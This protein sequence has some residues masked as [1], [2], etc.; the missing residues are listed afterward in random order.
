M[1][2]IFSA[3]RAFT[4]D[5]FTT[6]NYVSLLAGVP[7]LL[8]VAC[9]GLIIGMSAP[10]SVQLKRYDQYQRAGVGAMQVDDHARAKLWFERAL[11]IRPDEPRVQ[12][13]LAEATHHDGEPEVAIKIL[14][15]VIANADR[16]TAA[17][18]ALL[19]VEIRMEALP[20]AENDEQRRA[21][22][23]S[24]EAFARIALE[25]APESRDAAGALA[26]ILTQTGRVDVAIETL[27]PIATQHRDFYVTLAH[28][29]AANRDPGSA[30]R[31]AEN[32][33][34]FLKPQIAIHP[35]NFN[36]RSALANMLQQTGDFNEATR[37]LNDGMRLA[38]DEQKELL[39][40]VYV[41][42]ALREFDRLSDETYSL[43]ILQK[44]LALLDQMLKF[45]PD[46]LKVMAR[47][48][49]MVGAYE[50]LDEKY[51]AHLKQSLTETPYPETIH[52]ILGTY[53]AKAEQFD[54]AL[55]H[56]DA[57]HRSDLKSATLMNNLAWVIIA[58]Q[59]QEAD[60]ALTLVEAA[61]KLRPTDPDLI[62]TR[63][64]IFF[65]QE[66]WDE[67]RNDFESIL[68]RVEN[69]KQ[70]HERLAVIYDKLGKSDIAELHRSKSQ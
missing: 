64:E 44:Q 33:V 31:Y 26:Q 27:E 16:G 51:E 12:L 18:A 70:V 22:L 60:R 7:A 41:G 10:K 47:L 65:K 38:N 32:A 50:F 46:N 39:S 45:R 40:E 11:Q 48:A 29:A 49:R 59:P 20:N 34:Q 62:S 1:I 4:S 37:L 8:G 15:D 2:D 25:K 56:L 24:S 21:M 63:A 36:V 23:H 6:R 69:Q 28:L 52:L 58:T 13:A 42:I 17:K 35:N 53:Y 9:V 14:Q 30:K 67:A 57:A 19:A 66:R 5:W 55:F 68:G 3:L 43:Q 54:E 61:I